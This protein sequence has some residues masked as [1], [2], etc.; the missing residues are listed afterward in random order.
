MWRE[1]I[2]KLSRGDQPIGDPNPERGFFLGAT[3]DELAKA[4]RLLGVRLPD[5]PTGLLCESN[6]VT[7]MS[8]QSLA[9]DI[10]EIVRTNLAIRTDQQY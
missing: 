3:R 10:G 8:G 4:E 9:W 2:C 5:G 1:L 6:G 7:V